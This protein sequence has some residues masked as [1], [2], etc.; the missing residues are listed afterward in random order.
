M[1]RNRGFTAD[2]LPRRLGSGGFDSLQLFYSRALVLAQ[3]YKT[4]IQ[5]GCRSGGHLRPQR[6]IF[7]PE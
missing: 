5:K 1:L 4:S 2:F 7:A 3:E 6:V